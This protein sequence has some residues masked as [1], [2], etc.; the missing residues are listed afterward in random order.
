MPVVRRDPVGVVGTD[1]HQANENSEKVPNPA[2]VSSL[3]ALLAPQPRANHGF[4]NV[5]HDP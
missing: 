2:I 1:R 3:P 4:Q 5:P